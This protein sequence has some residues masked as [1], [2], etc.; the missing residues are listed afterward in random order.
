[1][2]TQLLRR[3]RLVTAGGAP[4]DDPP[5]SG[6]LVRARAAPHDDAPDARRE[7]LRTSGLLLVAYLLSRVVVLGAVA[8]ARRQ[9]GLDWSRAFAPWDGPFYVAIVE[10]GYPGFIPEAGQ[11]H[12]ATAA[13]FPL[14]PLVV[15]GLSEVTG[16]PVVVGG[17]VL[18]TLLGG[19]AVLAVHAAGRAF[20][21]ARTAFLAALVVVAMPGSATF[22]LFMSDPLLVVLAASCLL[23]LARHRWTA[24][25]LVA[26]AATATRPNALGLVA[27]AAVAS[28]L[29]VRRDRDL[30]SLVAPAL[31]PLG[32]LGYWGFLWWHTGRPDAWFVVQERF[33][34]QQLDF[35]IEFAYIVTGFSEL[36]HDHTYLVMWAGFLW[37]ALAAWAA[38]RGARIPAVPA[39]YTLVLL[40][41]M[42]AYSGV[43]PRPRFLLAAFPLVW[44]VVQALRGRAVIALC[45]VLL[46]AQAL[47]AWAYASQY[48]IP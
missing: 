14:F 29:A 47:V 35:G 42:L 31:A 39:T 16:L 33:W 21:P 44:L 10:H 1:M 4:T 30:R 5:E 11:G 43:G 22:S 3:A 6:T 19:A 25:G 20:L 23:L 36:V 7:R 17:V 45:G 27:A 24:A 34:H 28:F 32:V 13:F 38:W 37:L 15:R 48:V 18:N 26:M 2:F 9:Q 46:V 40:G 12:L 41:Q 8:V